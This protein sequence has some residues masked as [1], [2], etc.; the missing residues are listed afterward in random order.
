MSSEPIVLWGPGSEW[1]WIM[2]QF[3]VVAVTLV[4]IYFQ[5][6]L[7]RAANAFEH[8]SRLTDEGESE[9]MLRAKLRVARAVAAGDPAPEGAMTVIANYWETVASL[10]RRGHVSR[11]DLYDSVG[12][13]APF[14]WAALAD[15]AM[16]VRR[17]R[18]EPSIFERFEWLAR[19]IS[20][21]AAKKHEPFA[22]DHDSVVRIFA[23]SIPGLED[24]IRMAEEARLPP[25][26]RDHA[27]AR[28]MAGAVGPLLRAVLRSS[29]D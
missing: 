17:R 14:W 20:A 26:R 12:S 3:V 11:S 18:N 2:L 6:R 5:F 24:R 19:E 9:P 27:G 15:A 21:D 13:G 1:F 4:G 29:D 16:D 25:E 28:G 22:F 10:V 7:Q 8:V 23:A